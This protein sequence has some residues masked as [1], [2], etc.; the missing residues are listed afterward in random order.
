M[1]MKKRVLTLLMIG[2]LAL[3]AAA[4]SFGVK[5][6]YLMPSEQAFKDIYGSGPMF[7]AEIGFRLTGPISAYVEGMYFKRTGEL[8]YTK[9]STT[10]TLMPFGAG[11]RYDFTKGP[12]VVY[13]GAGLRYYSYK[14]KNVIGT[15]TASGIG[16]VGIA[17]VNVRVM[18]GIL[19]DVRAAFSS[20]KLSPAD[21]SINVGG[22]ELGGGLI[23][24]F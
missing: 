17:G 19:L 6:V 16:F 10:L 13:A 8:T 20:C 14:E 22:I 4:A 3:P 2:A 12:A 23:V 5:A 18:R 1:E 7:G 9:E 11:A 21:F 24:E 15:A